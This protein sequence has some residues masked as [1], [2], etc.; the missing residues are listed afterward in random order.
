MING[1]RERGG[2]AVSRTLDLAVAT[3]RF[4]PVLGNLE[5]RRKKNEDSKKRRGKNKSRLG[6]IVFYCH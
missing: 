3:L 4:G 6:L 1:G 2:M 5:I